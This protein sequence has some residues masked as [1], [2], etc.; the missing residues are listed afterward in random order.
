MVF[1]TFVCEKMLM[2]GRRG[3]KNFQFRVEIT[4]THKQSL[5]VFKSHFF[6]TL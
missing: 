6:M 5:C 2:N 3:E 4:H 1:M